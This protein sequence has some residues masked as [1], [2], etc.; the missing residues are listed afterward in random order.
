MWFCGIYVKK[1][2]ISNLV[3]TLICQRIITLN[4]YTGNKMNVIKYSPFDYVFQRFGANS[5]KGIGATKE[6]RPFKFLF[7]L[8]RSPHPRILSIITHESITTK[9]QAGHSSKTRAKNILQS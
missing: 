3:Q 4:D 6:N 9:H 8:H 7:L 1:T 2:T 5:C